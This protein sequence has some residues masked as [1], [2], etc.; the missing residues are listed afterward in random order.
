[1]DALLFNLTILSYALGLVSSGVFFF[2][3]RHAFFTAALVSVVAGFVLHTAYLTYEGIRLGTCPLTNLRDVVA[4]F[5][6]TV[7]LC[8]FISYLRYRIQALSLFLLPLVALFMLGTAFVRSTPI[9][10]A[11]RSSWMYFH[12][13]FLALAY[14]MF[15]VTFVAG[16]FYIFQERELKSRKPKTFYY[17][18]PS[19][20]LIDDLFY[21]FLIAG[22]SFMTL[23]I[24]AGVI[25]AEQ[26]WTAGWQSD[27]KVIATMITWAIY[28]A[29][30]LLRTSAGWRGRR[31]ALVNIA[32]F[33]SVLFTFVSAHFLG[34]LHKF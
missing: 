14:G 23:G 19:L 18:L 22:F 30:I 26:K 12:I 32:G 34:G 33:L 6:W 4:F 31:T 1:M 11:L 28:L 24:L 9:P 2:H 13:L 3:R 15:F 27:A 10:A 16:L 17:R 21:K 7:S 25:W 8:F 29:L 20:E 5:A